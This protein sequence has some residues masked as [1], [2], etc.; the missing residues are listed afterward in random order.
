MRRPCTCLSSPL[1]TVIIVVAQ[2]SPSQAA[3]LLACAR[4]RVSLRSSSTR[5]DTGRAGLG[6]ALDPH[7][8]WQAAGLPPSSHSSSSSSSSSNDSSER[9]R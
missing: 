9:A 3:Q 7:K 6:C 1:I 5:V 8:G 2:Q 4:R